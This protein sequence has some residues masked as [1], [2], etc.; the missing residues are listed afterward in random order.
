MRETSE[1]EHPREFAR[2]EKGLFEEEILQQGMY[3]TLLGRQGQDTGSQE[4][5]PL[6]RQVVS[7]EEIQRNTRVQSGIRQKDLLQSGVHD[8]SDGRQDQEAQPQKLPQAV[9]QGCSGAVPD[10]RQERHKAACPPHRQRPNEQR[11]RQLNNVVRFLPSSLAFAEL[12]G[13]GKEAEALQVLQ[14]AILSRRP[15]LQASATLAEIWQSLSDEEA[16]EIWLET[17]GASLILPQSPLAHG[18]PRKLGPSLAGI[19][20]LVRGARRNRVGR[21]RG[22]GNA[23]VPEVAAEFVRA[24]MEVSGIR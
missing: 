19:R 15:L 9:T 2:V 20:E 8:T 12:H 24:F 4:N 10:M 21:L 6:L 16:D 11:R 18:V 23:I 7:E 5:V 14:H 13:L 22:Y 17:G 1:T 3:G